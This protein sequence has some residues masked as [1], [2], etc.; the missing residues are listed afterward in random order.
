[1][2][3]ID[4][5]DN[6][7]LITGATSTSGF[8]TIR[9]NGNNVSLPIYT[10]NQSFPNID[11]VPPVTDLVIKNQ[12]I[13][14]GAESYGLFM[15]FSV[16]NSALCV[17]LYHA[18]KS[19]DDGIQVFVETPT[20]VTNARS[21]GEFFVSR[22][23]DEMYGIPLY[24]YDTSYP[25]LQTF[26]PV[27]TDV[28][29][30]LRV[31]PTVD[32]KQRRN[33]STN[34]NAKI[35]SYSDLIERIKMSLGHPYINLEICDDFQIC[36]NIDQGIEW[37][38]KYAGFTEEF[39]VFHSDLYEDGGL[40]ID[41]LFS[42]TP[43]IRAT[44]SSGLSGSYDYDLGDYRRVIG[45]FEFQQGE[46]SGVNTL[47]TLEQAMAQQTYFSYMLGNMGFDLVTW[48]VLKQW[49]D[50]REKMLAQKQ[51]ID[52]DERNQLLRIIPAPHKGSRYYG[53]VGCFV[54][55][56]VKDLI[57]ERWIYQYALALTKMTIGH[58]RGKYGAIQLFGGGSLNYNELMVQGEKEKDKL[59][60]ELQNG[61]GEVVP[62]R[63]F[64]GLLLAIVTPVSLLVSHI[65]MC[66]NG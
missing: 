25:D 51:Y 34:L 63:F 39:L 58:I 23:N 31:D 52:F 15:A 7:T 6:S 29:T 33:G 43:T 42:M 20:I 26:T 47:F 38:T 21:T 50:L 11:L 62:A 18:D 49:L 59:E 13:E 65:T 54:E 24:T 64:I 19:V 10:F 32:I 16:A 12:T 9:L 35:K 28:T 37:Y 66:I 45:I 41:E 60:A 1:M 46:T 5:L 14:D 48:E 3:Y 27:V 17:P 36:D 30:R 22:V 55:K 57:M 40:R 8:V 61:Y 44:N 53:V 2:K 4:N 56:A